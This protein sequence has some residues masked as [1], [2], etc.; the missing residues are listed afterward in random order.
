MSYIYRFGG[1]Q[2]SQT[3]GQP[4]S[5]TL[6][7]KVSEYRAVGRELASDLEICGLN[8][9][10]GNFIYN[11]LYWKDEK[12]GKKSPGSEWDLMFDFVQK[13]CFYL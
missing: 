10:T 11:Q 4:Y 1:I 13:N 6:P 7:Y 8:P 9:D 5:G 12:K 3:G 2:I